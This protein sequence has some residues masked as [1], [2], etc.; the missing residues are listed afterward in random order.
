MIQ[1]KGLESLT[2][3][4]QRQML[5]QLL[6]QRA[7]VN[8]RFPMSVQQQQLW[9]DY[10]RDPSVTAYNVFL[11]A[12]I[13]SEIDVEAFHRTINQLVDRHACLRTTFSDDDADLI[14]TVHDRLRP[15]FRVIESVRHDSFRVSS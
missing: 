5:Q 13:R 8:S 12:R 9:Y 7:I 14:Q 4:Q 3:E 1:P 6:R 2:P 10:R 15:E 11:P